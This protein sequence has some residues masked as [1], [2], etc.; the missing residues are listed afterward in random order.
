MQLI[1]ALIWVLLSGMMLLLEVIAFV[2]GREGLPT[3]SQLVKRWRGH[4]A[5]HRAI[6]TAL[7]ALV[8][9]ILYLHWVVELF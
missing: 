4:S 1:G 6:L 7:L 3:A 5:A 2:D 9:P 8:G